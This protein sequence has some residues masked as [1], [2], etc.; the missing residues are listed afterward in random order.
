[1]G[2]HCCGYALGIIVAGF[3]Y[4]ESTSIL[5]RSIFNSIDGLIKTDKNLS[6]NNPYISQPT[7]ILY[8]IQNVLATQV[9]NILDSA[10]CLA[11]LS[12]AAF[13]ILLIIFQ[14]NVG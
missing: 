13:V 8:V 10:I 6:F 2:I 7:K 1:M 5:A 3:V 9:T 14:G 11:A 12:V 4:R